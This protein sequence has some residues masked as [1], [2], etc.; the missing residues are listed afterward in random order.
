MHRKCNSCMY[1][2]PLYLFVGLLVINLCLLYNLISVR[3]LSTKPG[4]G[5]LLDC[6][7]SLHPILRHTIVKH[8]Q[9]SCDTHST[10]T[11][12]YILFSNYSPCNSQTRSRDFLIPRRGIHLFSLEKNH[13][14]TLS[15]F[16]LSM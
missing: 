3:D 9:T 16:P 13:S 5:V 4:S 1:I 14:C 11:L 7:D 6:I 2:S 15:L 12:T 10:I 8:I